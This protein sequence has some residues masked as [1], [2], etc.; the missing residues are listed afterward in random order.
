LFEDDI[1]LLEKRMLHLL[2][3]LLVDTEISVGFLCVDLNEE[4]EL[5]SGFQEQLDFFV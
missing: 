1:S 2:A 5:L 3:T 4:L